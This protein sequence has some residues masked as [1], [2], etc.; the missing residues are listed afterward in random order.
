VDLRERQEL[1]NGFGRTFSRAFEMAGTMGIFL[2]LGWLVDRA[3]GTKPLF[4]IALFLFA[5]AG[6]GYMAWKR[7]DEEMQVHEAE[8]VW[9]RRKGPRPSRDVAA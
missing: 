9:N 8:A 6:M 3:L 1:N 4:M 2:G 5:I 7:Y